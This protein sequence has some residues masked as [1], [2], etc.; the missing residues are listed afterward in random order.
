MS[1]ASIMALVAP[2]AMPLSLACHIIRLIM[3]YYLGLATYFPKS[4]KPG[5]CSFAVATPIK[6][7]KDSTEKKINI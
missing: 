7:S 4:L 5:V 3:S 6:F 1:S 2:W